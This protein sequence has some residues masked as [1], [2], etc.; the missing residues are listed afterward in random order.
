[1]RYA[2]AMVPDGPG[3]RLAFSEFCAQNVPVGL[4]YVDQPESQF[5][6]V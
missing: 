5:G 3:S 6:A 4:A 2:K 1:M